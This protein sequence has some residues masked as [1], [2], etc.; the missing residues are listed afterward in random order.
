MT[1]PLFAGDTLYGETEVLGVRPSKSRPTQGIVQ[2]RTRGFNQDKV[3]V[4]QFDRSVLIPKRGHAI[5]DKA[6]Y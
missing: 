6:D 1:A 5:D 3:L 2:V 4:C